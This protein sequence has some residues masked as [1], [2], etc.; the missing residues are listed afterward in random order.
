MFVVFLVHVLIFYILLLFV[1]ISTLTEL[2]SAL[3]VLASM[4]LF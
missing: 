1:F 2:I 4:S 3:H